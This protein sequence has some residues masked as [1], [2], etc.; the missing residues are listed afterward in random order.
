MPLL[1]LKD[2]P[3]YDCLLEAA[4]KFPDLDPSATEVFLHLLRAGDVA[5]D[6]CNEHLAKR[7]FSQGRFTVL[8]LLFDKKCCEGMEHSPAQLAEMAGVTRATMTGLIDTLERDGFVTRATDPSDRRQMIVRLTDK[9]VQFLED[10]LPEHFRRMAGLM[11]TLTE[12][13]RKTLVRLLNKIVA[14]AAALRPGA[15]DGHSSS[16]PAAAGGA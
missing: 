3:R 7:N 15:D 4:H 9:G 8:M 10:F 6:V 1:M 12:N 14:Q 13:D 2:L 11:A 16:G 5:F